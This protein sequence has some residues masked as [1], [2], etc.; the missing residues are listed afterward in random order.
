LVALL[1]P[2]SPLQAA[3]AAEQWEAFSKIATAITGTFSTDRITFGNGKSLPFSP[4]GT[5]SRY[6]EKGTPA[7]SG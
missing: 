2:H 1:Q 4:A 7:C 6:G 3:S 5:T